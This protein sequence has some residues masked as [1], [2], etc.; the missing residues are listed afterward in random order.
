[1]SGEPDRRTLASH[2][3]SSIASQSG[4]CRA[5]PPRGARTPE[6]ERA[7]WLAPLLVLVAGGPGGQ[8]P[9]GS[10]C[11]R[12]APDGDDVA[13]IAPGV[14]VAGGDG[15]AVSLRA[16]LSPIPRRRIPAGASRA[17]RSAGGRVVVPTI[18]I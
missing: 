11:C 3:G 17:T 15:P 6:R 13:F 8:S 10:L 18:G 9:P 14:D 4:H 2:H 7:R 5:I 16:G 1:M 12:L